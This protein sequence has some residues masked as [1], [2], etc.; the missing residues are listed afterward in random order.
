MKEATRTRLSELILEELSEKIKRQETLRRK[1]EAFTDLPVE[2]VA[3]AIL[4]QFEYLL[5]SDL[6]EL[7]VH[8]IEQEVQEEESSAAAKR[9]SEMA[10]REAQS[11]G[12]ALESAQLSPGMGE[13]DSMNAD[14]PAESIM[15]HFGPK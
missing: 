11:S 8:L 12:E 6:R 13:P 5:S 10:A 15:E 3:E 9:E 4:K 1:L 14:Y 2:K 7:I